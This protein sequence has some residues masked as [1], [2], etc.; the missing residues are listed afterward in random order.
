MIE[1]AK[2]MVEEARKFDG[3]SSLSGSKRKADEL[4]E[5]S[6]E[7]QDNDQPSSKRAKVLKQDLKV[8]K[9]RS[10]AMLGVAVT[11]ALGLVSAAY[12]M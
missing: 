4:E 12:V 9:V 7:D 6:E 8:E 10:R 2:E 3:E 5:G 1:R 11:M